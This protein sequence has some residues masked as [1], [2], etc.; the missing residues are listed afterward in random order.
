MMLPLGIRR[1]GPRIGC[2]AVLLLLAIAGTTTTVAQSNTGMCAQYHADCY[3]CISTGCSFCYAGYQQRCDTSSYSCQQR[4]GQPY[5]ASCPVDNCA[6]LA[7][8]SSKNC[9][10]AV[11]KGCRWCFDG[12][13]GISGGSV[14]EPR[15]DTN[16]GTCVN[17]TLA[18]CAQYAPL[19]WSGVT[20][21][22]QFGEAATSWD[23]ASILVLV[24]VLVATA[25]AVMFKWLA[26]SAED[27]ETSRL[28]LDFR[29]ID[30]SLALIV[31]AWQVFGLLMALKM[32]FAPSTPRIPACGI[33]EYPERLDLQRQISRS[34]L[35][36]VTVI[37]ACV[38]MYSPYV[39]LKRS[40]NGF[41]AVLRYLVGRFSSIA[42]LPFVAPLATMPMSE[43]CFQSANVAALVY[44]FGIGQTCVI[45]FCVLVG[46]SVLTMVCCRNCMKW[47]RVLAFGLTGLA[48]L[49]L[50]GLGCFIFIQSQRG[51]VSSKSGLRS[52]FLQASAPTT[53]AL[54][55][56]LRDVTLYV[57]YRH[58]P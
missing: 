12:T 14:L 46:F 53:L 21:D 55:A 40:H 47:M 17:A 2:A 35:A 32:F 36:T 19:A 48:F 44:F 13:S 27:F 50:A 20:Y 7:A 22:A 54:F 18:Q 37:Y 16:V 52:F 51:Q 5:T 41:Q 56:L 23:Y 42:L 15:D 45:I 10:G 9:Q 8:G 38:L 30:T 49:V 31:N 34:W 28:R 57:K 58:Y 3:N 25:V 4:G 6:K 29:H 26:A 43:P 39:L 11:A 1:G 33:F 24:F